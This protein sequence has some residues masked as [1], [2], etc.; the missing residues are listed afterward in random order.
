MTLRTQI[1]E[2]L[3]ENR[4]T[5]SQ[6]SLRTYTS[7][8]YNLNKKIFDT[9]SIDNLKQ[10]DTVIEFLADTPSGKRKSILSALVVLLPHHSDK[11]RQLMMSDNNTYQ[12][13]ELSQLRTETQEQNWITQEELHRT[14]KSCE[15]EAKEYFKSFKKMTIAHMGGVQCI[16]NY[17][18]LLLMSGRHMPI[19]RALDWSEMKHKDAGENDNELIIN[20][21]TKK[22][23]TRFIFR[24]YKTDNH[25]GVQE[26]PIPTELKK[27]L[28][29]YLKY[30]K[31]VCPETPYL[32]VD[33][34]C[35]KLTS[36]KINQ[37]LEKIFNRKVGINSLR[38]SYITEKYNNLP[39]LEEMKKEAELFGH[40]LEE[41][42]L[43]IRK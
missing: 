16:Q 11:Y 13:Q 24:R 34:N 35:N 36:V 29:E 25:Y 30:L 31:V 21:S 27:I 26:V 43:Y 38:H 28:V 37:R 40:G 42:L 39:P 17:L 22:N 19:R 12:Q 3:I 7:T 6:S 41:H 9:E 2:L 33:N 4:P 1:S 32:F 8:L 10:Q 15:K 14:I 5:L 18:L 23:Q 20:P